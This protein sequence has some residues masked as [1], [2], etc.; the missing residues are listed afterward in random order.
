V[1][2]SMNRRIIRAIEAIHKPSREVT[3]H[4]GVI[5]S[6]NDTNN[7]TRAALRVFFHIRREMNRAVIHEFPELSVGAGGRWRSDLFTPETQ[8]TC[9]LSA[10]GPDAQTK[11]TPETARNDDYSHYSVYLHGL[12]G[13]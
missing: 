7:A 5:K 12:G 13:R 4:I 1:R 3:S 11:N 2:P 6:P 8:L 10:T 9:N